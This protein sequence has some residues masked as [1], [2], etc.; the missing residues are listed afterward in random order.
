MYLKLDNKSFENA[1]TRVFVRIR[2]LE[3]SSILCWLINISATCYVLLLIEHGKKGKKGP[4]HWCKTSL[5][6]TM[7]QEDFWLL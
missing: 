4:L 5:F 3:L 1:E 6:F 2:Y 7:N